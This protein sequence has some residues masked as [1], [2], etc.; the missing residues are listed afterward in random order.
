MSQSNRRHFLFHCIDTI[1]FYRCGHCK[2]LA[3]KYEKAAQRMKNESP[4]VPFAKVD[5]TVESDLGS[6]FEVQG[7]PTLKIFRKGQAYDYDGPREEDG[8][9]ISML[10]L[11]VL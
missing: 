6:R 2:T 9:F 8:K 7:Y 5:A 1:F 3:P 11:I 10:K 4:P